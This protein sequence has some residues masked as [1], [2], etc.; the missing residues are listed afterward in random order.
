MRFVRNLV[1]QLLSP[2]VYALNT[3]AYSFFHTP[4]QTTIYY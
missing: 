3:F 2:F 1:S 4:G